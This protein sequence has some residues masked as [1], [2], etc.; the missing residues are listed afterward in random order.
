MKTAELCS[1]FG[2][3]ESTVHT[4][5]RVIEKALAISML[6][7]KWTV[8]ALLSK[9]PLVWMAEVNGV[10]VDLRDMP[11]EIQ[12]AAVDAGIIPFLPP[13]RNDKS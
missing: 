6:D 12:Q 9:N 5:T 7:T 3:G 8:P 4:K 1:A 2:V 11:H 10:V 13:P